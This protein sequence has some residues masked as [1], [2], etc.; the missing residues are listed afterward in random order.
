MP[1]FGFQ[2]KDEEERDWHNDDQAITAALQVLPQTAPL[3]DVAGRHYHIA[4]DSSLGFLDKAPNIAAPD[5]N[6]N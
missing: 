6:L 4:C 5:V 1:N 2:A 3:H